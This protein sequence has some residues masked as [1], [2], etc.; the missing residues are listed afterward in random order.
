MSE[1]GS[2]ATGEQI[3]QAEVTRLAHDLRLACMRVSRRVRFEASSDLAPHQFSALGRLEQRARTLTELAECE[4][5]SVPS[6]SRTV[7]ALV[8][9]GVVAR[10]ADPSDGRAVVLSI[11]AD[12]VRLLEVERA[13]RDAWMAR[14][15]EELDAADH[16]V[17]A[18]ATQILERVMAQ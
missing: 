18:R 14:Q 5:I 1:E 16:T 9:R 11:T 8:D 12:G 6:M 2:G 17:L 10:A 15:L 13:Q 3:D 4:R 7:A